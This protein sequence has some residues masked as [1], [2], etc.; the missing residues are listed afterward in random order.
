VCGISGVLQTSE[1]DEKVNFRKIENYIDI[2]INSVKL[3]GPNNTGKQKVSNGFLGHT[4]LA[5]RDLS[6]ASN[7]PIILE[8]SLGV[9]V[10]NGEIYNNKEIQNKYSLKKTNSDTLDLKNLFEYKGDISFINDLV[11]DFAIAYWDDITRKLYLIR[12]HFGKKPLYYAFFNDFFFFNSS[13][14]GIQNLIKNKTINNNALTN[15]LVY[16]NMFGE[17]TIFKDIKQLKPGN[18]LIWDSCTGKIKY[19][20]FFNFRGEIMQESYLN[21]NYHQT[22]EILSETLKSV[23]SSHLCSDVPLSLLLSSGIDSK[24]VAKYS[25]SDNLKAYTADFKNNHNEVNDSKKFSNHYNQL[26]HEIVNIKNFDVFNILEKI[27]EFIGEPFADASIVPLFCLY[28]NL[29]KER[30]VVLQGDGGDELFGGYRRYQA[31]DNLSN[32]PSNRYFNRISKSNIFNHRLNR[33]I[34]LSTLQNEELYKNIMTTDFPGFNTISFFKNYLNK[35][36]IKTEEIIGKEY[37]RTF[38]STKNLSIEEQLSAI[39]FMN[40]LPNQFLYKV[41]RVSMMCGIEARVPLVDLRLIKL[42]FE[43]NPVFRFRKNPTKKLLRDSVNIPNEYKLTPKRGF[44]TPI[45]KWMQ[46]SKSYLESNIISDSFIEF[47]M[48]DKRNMIRLINM[49]KYS[50]TESYCLW[51]I[52]CLSIWFKKV[53]KSEY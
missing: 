13:I 12:D 7:Q 50:A 21:K 34:Y 26:D 48:L 39:D 52:L 30:K 2:L 31:F 25:L 5:I 29:P 41:D 16:G 33:I 28:S 15:Y 42:I 20:Q 44:G 47:F 53:F 4:R 1:N 51:K 17:N 19:D 38:I 24:V 27:I 8:N 3:R 37:T 18:I 6:I 23:V 49:N 36:Q 45:S 9:F 11:G 22:T 43:I 40:Q 10:Y 32:F 46:E 35:K 14:N